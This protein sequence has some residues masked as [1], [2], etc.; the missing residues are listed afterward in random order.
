MSYKISVR[1]TADPTINDDFTK[2]Y[3]VGQVWV[4][5]ATK[6]VW[7]L[8][9]STAGAAFWERTELEYFSDLFDVLL[10][11][12]AQGAVLYYSSG[13][14]WVN[15]PAGTLGF[16]LKAQGASA[17]PIWSNPGA[18]NVFGS[19]YNSFTQAANFSVTATGVGSFVSIGNNFPTSGV[20]LPIGTYLVHY[21]ADF[22][23]SAIRDV[24]LRIT[25]TT[26]A[27]TLVTSESY[28]IS[29]LNTFLCFSGQRQISFVSAASRSFDFL[30]SGEST[31]SPSLLVR[32]AIITY[33]R[34]S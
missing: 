21:C 19:E 15:L 5:T 4:N 31:G 34:I 22:G 6:K 9:D 16:F 30:V 29:F 13:N 7:S 17:D 23:C 26:T 24:L 2:G 25:E 1:A 32:Q 10:S 33:W 8:S 14:K 27:T 12:P 3:T 20:V 11:S 28:H 18:F